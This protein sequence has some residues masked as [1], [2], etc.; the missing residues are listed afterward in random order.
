MTTTWYD[1]GRKFRSKFATLAEAWHALNEYVEDQVAHG[2]KAIPPSAPVLLQAARQRTLHL[3]QVEA[4]HRMAT[5]CTRAYPR[6]MALMCKAAAAG[7]RHPKFVVLMPDGEELEVSLGKMGDVAFVHV[8]GG[9]VAAG[10]YV[11]RIDN[12]LGARPACRWINGNV[13]TQDHLDLLDAI[14]ADP[15]KVASQHG[16]ATGRCSFCRR[17]LSTKESRAVGYGP[18]CAETHGLP[19]GHVPDWFDAEGRHAQA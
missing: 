8:A 13:T 19:W 14:E 3:G 18:D 17:L 15:A 4:I 11:G 12:S 16:V 1:N 2:G 9:Y 6:I 10:M 5:A 7:K